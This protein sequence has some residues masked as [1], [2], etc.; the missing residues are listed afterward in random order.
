MVQEKF[1][2]VNASIM[3]IP[4]EHELFISIANIK[5]L[6]FLVIFVITQLSAAHS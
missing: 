6:S 2:V 4:K 3:L 5:V 1:S